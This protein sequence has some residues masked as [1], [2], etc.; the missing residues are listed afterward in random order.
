MPLRRSSISGLTSKTLRGG[1]VAG[2]ELASSQKSGILSDTPEL[3]T[4]R[5]ATIPEKMMYDVKELTVKTRKKVS[6]KFA[7]L[8]T[9]CL[10]T[11][12]GEARDC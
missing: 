6:L 5:I 8:L 10:T 12:A 11:S 9:S 1:I 3:T 4:I 2:A 7:K